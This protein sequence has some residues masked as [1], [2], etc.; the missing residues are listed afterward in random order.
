MFY[1][2]GADLLVIFHLGFV[3]FVVTGGFLA[4][5]RRWVMSLH[6]PAAIWGALIEFNGWLCPLTSLEQELR[7]A[8]GQ[9]GYAGG[10]ID[11]YIL[12]VL[13]PT[14]LTRGVQIVIG[15]LVVVINTLA[16]GWMAYNF[17]PFHRSK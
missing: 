10:F 1:R 5:R 4:L 2:I 9:A 14:D 6:I 13:Y 17:N 15:V 8:G 7:R 11:Y 16:Y 3:V 12:P